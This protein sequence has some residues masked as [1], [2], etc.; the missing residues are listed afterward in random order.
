MVHNCHSDRWISTKNATS[1]RNYEHINVNYD[2]R[3]TALAYLYDT[4]FYQTTK[5][6][7]VKLKGKCHTKRMKYK[8]KLETEK[9]IYMWLDLLRRSCFAIHIEMNSKRH[10]LFKNTILMTSW[11]SN[12]KKIQQLGKL[13]TWFL[14][15]FDISKR[16]KV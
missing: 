11:R 7:I 14:V 4:L 1:L 12:R 15:Y 5:E 9:N 10:C 13:F 2:W 16:K 3:Q 8:L 6:Q